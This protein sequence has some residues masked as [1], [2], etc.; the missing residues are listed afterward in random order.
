[1][2]WRSLALLVLF[3]VFIGCATK[4]EAPLIATVHYGADEVGKIFPGDTMTIIIEGRDAFS[5][6]YDHKGLH[7]PTMCGWV[8][9]SKSRTLICDKQEVVIFGDDMSKLGKEPISFTSPYEVK[10]IP[11]PPRSKKNK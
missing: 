6:V 9:Q 4:E 5:I 11:Q 2:F 3:F 8:A 10:V 1:M 7:A